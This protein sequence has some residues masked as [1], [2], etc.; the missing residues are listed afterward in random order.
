[1]VVIELRFILFTIALHDIALRKLSLIAFAE[2]MDNFAESRLIISDLQAS[3][4]QPRQWDDLDKFSISVGDTFAKLPPRPFP[5]AVLDAATLDEK[6]IRMEFDRDKKPTARYAAHDLLISDKEN[7]VSEAIANI[8]ILQHQKLQQHQKETEA[9]IR[10]DIEATKQAALSTAHQQL[11][12]LE[13]ELSRQKSHF[14]ILLQT[15]EEQFQAVIKEKENRCQEL[16]SRLDNEGKSWRKQIQEKESYYIKLLSDQEGDFNQKLTAMQLQCQGK[17]DS[18]LA[19]H[20]HDQDLKGLADQARLQAKEEEVKQ[21]YEKKLKKMEKLVQMT[22]DKYRDK[23]MV[24][25][26]SLEESRRE[27]KALKDSIEIK[28]KHY[29][30]HLHFQDKRLL[31]AQ[32]RLE[33]L[34]EVQ[35]IADIWK[36]TAKEL[37]SYVIRTC[38]TVGELPYDFLAM[39]G[40][41]ESI[42][43]DVFEDPTAT[44][45]NPKDQYVQFTKTRHVA[46]SRAQLTR[47]LRLSNVIQ[48]RVKAELPK[49]TGLTV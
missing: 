27:V 16:L 32:H 34:D 15:K 45:Y 25:E 40:K 11:A 39:Q 21:Q 6:L 22:M 2:T 38:G 5:I 7:N 35:R 43:M 20:A 1:M 49:P 28:E 42:A 26:G 9:L 31:E 29:K 18:L 47:A 14:E 19:K 8:N 30:E 4:A 33:T 10:V 48:E 3:R 17:I 23:E 46:V 36:E 37:S 13:A 41:G 44:S 24:M 12:Q